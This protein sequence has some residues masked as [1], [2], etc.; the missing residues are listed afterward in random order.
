MLEFRGR[1]LFYPC[2]LARI[3]EIQEHPHSTR[4]GNIIVQ[5]S[6]IVGENPTGRL[7]DGY[8]LT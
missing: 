6:R 5:L 1:I 3:Q 7:K 4:P 8:L 2:V